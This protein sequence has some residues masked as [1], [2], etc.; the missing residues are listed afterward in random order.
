M[1]NRRRVT[2]I[3]RGGGVLQRWMQVGCFSVSPQIARAH[4]HTHTHRKVFTEDRRK[5][6]MIRVSSNQLQWAPVK[7]KID[8][9][10]E[11]EGQV[12]EGR[13]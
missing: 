2:Y 11:A 5:T 13:V 10:V 3:Q 8:P 12:R 9:R 7:A 1:S 4:T 6:D